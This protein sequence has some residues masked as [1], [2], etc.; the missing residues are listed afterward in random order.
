LVEMDISQKEFAELMNVDRNSISRI[1]NN[2]SQPPL[3][4]LFEIAYALGIDAKDLLVSSSSIESIFLK[5]KKAK[6]LRK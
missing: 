6:F 5:E 4:F 2:K 1:C 3:K